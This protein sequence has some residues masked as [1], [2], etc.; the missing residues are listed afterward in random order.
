MKS[1]KSGKNVD[2]VVHEVGLNAEKPNIPYSFLRLIT[3][4]LG[5]ARRLNP[6]Y[7]NFFYCGNL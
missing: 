4:L 2:S 5:F 6:T 1:L 7:I 3:D